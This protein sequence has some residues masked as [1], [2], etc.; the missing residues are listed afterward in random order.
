MW[1]WVHYCGLLW[2]SSAALANGSFIWG[3]ITYRQSYWGLDLSLG[4]TGLLFKVFVCSLFLS[5]PLYLLICFKI[6]QSFWGFLRLFFLIHC[7]RI[8][9]HF[10][11]LVLWKNIPF[12]LTFFAF[13]FS[14][15]PKRVVHCVP[16][17]LGSSLNMTLATFLPKMKKKKWM[18]KGNADADSHC[19]PS[20]PQHSHWTQD[21]VAISSA[22]YHVVC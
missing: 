8:S 11:P 16:Q 2:G 5:F 6:C 13:A 15:W 17:T 9:W 10:F 7:M 12:C 1:A 20:A 21:S 19:S 18:E 14:P 3:V 22:A 4:S